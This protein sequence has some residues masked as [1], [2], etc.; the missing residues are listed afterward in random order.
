MIEFKHPLVAYAEPARKGATVART[1]I[2]FALVVAFVLIFVRIARMGTAEALVGRSGD[3]L[4]ASSADLHSP[5]GVLMTLGSFLAVWPALWLV[6]PIVHKRKANTL[7]G[8]DGKMKWRHFRLGMAASMLVGAAAWGPL[9]YLHAD[10]I[11]IFPNLRDWA[12][13]AAIAMP[14]VF[15]QCVAE[16]LMFRGYLLQQFAARSMSV[17]G[18]SVLPSILF[19]L[20]HPSDAG[21]LSMSWYHFVFGLVMAA[22]TSRT[23]NLGAAAGIHFGN[24]LINLLLIAPSQMVSGLA[25]FAIPSSVDFSGSRIA[26][27]VMMFIGAALF[28]GFMDLRFIRAWQR[29]KRE[30]AAAAEAVAPGPD[31]GPG[32]ASG[33]GPGPGPASGPGA[34]PSTL[35]AL[36]AE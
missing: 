8:P 36:A 35:K 9:V 3:E 10:S 1:L 32:P 34:R 28:M 7:F 15:V 13:L 29:A 25:L 23:A 22:V 33:P 11:L 5:L 18:W 30:R 19:G 21:L 16:E 14:M 27:L 4:V 24:N 31:S 17:L 20:A 6:L 2:G 26:Y 12:I